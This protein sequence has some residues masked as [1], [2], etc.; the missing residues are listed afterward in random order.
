MRKRLW[1]RGVD[2]EVFAPAH[3]IALDY[4]RPIF[5]S[6]GRIA[7]E[8]NLEAFL[9]LD[10]PGTKLVIGQGP[11]LSA[12]QRRFPDARFLGLVEDSILAAHLAAADVFVF[13]SRTDTFGLVLLE[14][15]AS[16][17]PIAGFPVAATR[18]VV[19]TAP[20]A[21]LD[22]DLRSACLTAL[23][24]PRAARRPIPSIAR[25]RRSSG[26]SRSHPTSPTTCTI[27]CTPLPTTGH[28]S[29]S[30]GTL[31]ATSSSGSRVWRD[32]RSASSRIS[33]HIWPARSTSTRR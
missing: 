3:A 20:V 13:P 15:L 8:K 32:G 23:T 12:L 16:G 18:D 1:T 9:S 31:R 30:I 14:A 11:Q 2:S 24:I 17:L 5:I 27:S 21:A 33:R 7:V 4:P 26:S 10:L 28:S 19:G 6:V 25:T 22:E 29:R